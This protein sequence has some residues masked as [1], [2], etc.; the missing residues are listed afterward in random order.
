MSIIHSSFFRLSLPIVLISILFYFMEEVAILVEVNFNLAAQLPYFL[1]ALCIIL[2]QSFNQGRMG[3]I[4]VAMAIAYWVIQ[5]RLQHPLSFGTTKIEYVLLAFTFPTACV[6]VYLF[7]EKRFFSL[8]FSG[9]AYCALIAALLAWS[10]LFVDHIAIN[11]ISET[12]Q[13][14]LFEIPQVSRLP[15][16]IILYN[17]LVVG[18]F[19]IFI[20]KKNVII[21]VAIYTALIISTLTFVFFQYSYIS[22][23]LF[24]LGGVLLILYIMITNHS[25][26]YV[27]LLTNIPGRRA[28]ETEIKHLGKK[29]T[30]AMLDV[31]HF[32]KFNDTY[33]HDTGDDVLKLV[34]SQMTKIGGKARVYR[35]G[36]E[37]FTVLF[38]GKYVDEALEY[39]EELREN[40]ANYQMMIRNQ[41]M[42]P[43]SKLGLVNRGKGTRDKSVSVTISIGVADSYETKKP[44]HV[45]KN[46]DTALYK[47]KNAGRN[48]VSS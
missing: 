23:I 24:S 25:L 36:G 10:N 47:A 42:R 26:A 35:Y 7:P 41:D 2:C 18:L 22:T 48:C 31:D 33:G 6:V 27:D 19:G 15:F 5:S 9:F 43:K 14:I 46:A 13:T 32:K 21:D 3:M 1:F 39:L 34:A 38:K 17:A 45:L 12:W 29:Y 11:G 16:I 20:L 40:I 4:A 44:H 30:I 8:S 37:E 28:L